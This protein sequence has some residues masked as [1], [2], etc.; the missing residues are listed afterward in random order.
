MI[1][2]TYQV[3]VMCEKCGKKEFFD[4]SWKKSVSQVLGYTTLKDFD[5]QEDQIKECEITIPFKTVER[6]LMCLGCRKK[7]REIIVERGKMLSEFVHNTF[8]G[9][10]DGLDLERQ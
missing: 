2:R 7:C 8:P 9:Y 6:I 1:D 10:G 3:I 5:D 4:C